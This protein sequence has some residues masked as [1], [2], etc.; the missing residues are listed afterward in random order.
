[1]RETQGS[2]SSAASNR[3]GEIP[4][5]TGLPAYMR[6]R[7]LDPYSPQRLHR[8]ALRMRRL[9]RIIYA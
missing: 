2:V 6:M 1:M 5:L 7:R 3:V 8:L 4:R 9:R